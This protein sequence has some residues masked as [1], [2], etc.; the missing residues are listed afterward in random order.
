MMQIEKK[1]NAQL[2]HVRLRP[3]MYFGGTDQEAL[4][5]L[6]KEILSGSAEEAVIGRTQNIYL[7][8]RDSGEIFFADD[9]IGLPV[10]IDAESRLSNLERLMRI[11]S[12]LKTNEGNERY[13]IINS[14]LGI[15]FASVN[16]LCQTFI[17]QTA[18]DG[19]LW[20]QTYEKGIPVQPVEKVC[21]LTKDNKWGLAITFR[22][23]FDILQQN[24]FDWDF[25]VSR[26]TQIAYTAH[27]V[28]ITLVDKRNGEYQELTIHK[29]NG[30]HDFVITACKGHKLIG[31]IFHHASRLTLPKAESSRSPQYTVRVEV[32]LQFC[33][34]PTQAIHSFVNT[35]STSQGGVHVLATQA[36]VMNALEIYLL[37]KSYELNSLTWNDFPIGFQAAISILH[38]DPQFLSQT[39]TVFL[40]QDV[41]VPLSEAIFHAFWDFLQNDQ[42]DMKAWKLSVQDSHQ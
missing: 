12:I 37:K 30:L 23:D 2:T 5:N 16:G 20:Q 33:I 27:G 15:G 42:H 29:P 11:N 38:P 21:A 18:R 24:S 1:I 35:I 13:E 25:L 9:G 17:V 31:E 22:P 41:Y 10:D 7:E 32:A 39:K 6:L 14:M 3:G 4:H 34:S 28:K 26:C 8:L 40:N 19:Y 36:S